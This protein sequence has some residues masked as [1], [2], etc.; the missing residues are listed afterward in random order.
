MAIELRGV[1]KRY[2][3]TTALDN[4]SVK[5]GGGIVYGLLGANG[6]KEPMDFV[7]ALADLQRVCGVDQLKMSDYGI[8]KEELAAIARNARETMGGLFEVDP[9]EINNAAVL[10]I[11]EES[12]R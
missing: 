5:F 9:C 12:F 1:T 4:V 6:A 8:Q 3:A 7:R 2:G 11:L 10:K